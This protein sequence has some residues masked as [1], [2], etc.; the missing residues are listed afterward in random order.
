MK[1]DVSQALAFIQKLARGFVPTVHMHPSLL[2]TSVTD[3][4]LTAK[5]SLVDLTRTNNGSKK[6]LAELEAEVEVEVKL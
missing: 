1:I 5:L 4:T 2:Q 6:N 3:T